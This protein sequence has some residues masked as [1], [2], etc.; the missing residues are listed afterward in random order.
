MP[1][2][3][4]FTGRPRGMPL[5]EPTMRAHPWTWTVRR[6]AAVST[7]WAVV[8]LA[9]WPARAEDGYDLWL[10]YRPLPA[11]EA[12]AYRAHTTQLV[13]DVSTPMRG[14]A[15]AELLRAF[16]G[17]LGSAPAVTATITADGAILAGTPGSSPQIAGLH[18]SLRALG[19]E[20]YMIRSVTV[21]GHAATVIAANSD[22]GVL[23]G[24]FR[25]LRL[26][27][28]GESLR[29]LDLSDA[30]REKLR[31]L[32]H[33]DNLDGSVERGYAGNS[34]WNWSKLPDHLDP[35]YTDYA[36]AN[37]SIGINGV[38][39]N[40]VNA[41]A[42]IL[43]RDY[44]LKVAGIA[45]ALRPYGMRVYLSAR[46][47]APIELGGLKTAD[48][49][50]AAVRAWWRNK[51]DEIYA[52]VPDFGG[53]LVKANSEGQPGPGDY[54]RSHAAGAN[55]LADAVGRHRGVVMWR[56]FVY[57]SENPADRAT[58]AWTEFKPLD[59]KFRDNVLLQVKNGPIDFQPRE[60][61]SP[62]FG[63]MPGTP[64][65]MEFQVTKEYL[66]FATHLVYLGALYEEVLKAHT[67][68]GGSGPAVGDALAGTAGV[69]NIGADRDWCGSTFNQAN[70]Y[71]LGRLAWD[72]AQSARA[73]A[74]DWA[75][76]TLSHED[77]VV[78]AVVDMMMRSREAVV[79]YM[80]PLGLH[81]LMGRSHH[82]GPMPWDDAGPR[83][84]WTPVYYHRADQKGIGFDRTSTG[85]NAVAQYAPQ[86]AA[87]IGNLK[88]VPDEY[89]LWF[90]HVPWDYRMRSGQTLWEELVRRYTRGVAEVIAMR[91][92]W[93]GL[94]GR[95]D[96]ARHA[97]TAA[98]LGI[99]QE[100][101][102]WWRDASI[103]YWQS[104]NGLPM[105]P[106][107][108]APARTLE[109]YKSLW[110]PDQRPLSLS[111]DGTPL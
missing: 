66:G 95:I 87:Q 94:A 23:Y 47:S 89:L 35:R 16:S 60:P 75:R 31:V 34:I 107:F 83:P 43:T 91:A 90:H 111:G 92:T 13:L 52:L 28:T 85:S 6:V 79:D 42:R 7:L 18:L 49:L 73:I 36:R 15:R 100:E 59:G 71:A 44:L 33:W 25:L 62:L 53:F 97:R 110:A 101:A 108:A 5:V 96:A 32:D 51:A 104:L 27:Q 58:Q 19:N 30:P 106:G 81:H 8:L 77:A 41:N 21:D 55:M 12:A 86:V 50:D 105:P 2:V 67:K 46:F 4:F 99:Q 102:Q 48:P 72:P 84:E 56:A 11:E 24:A 20:G 9:A 76:M 109:H 38:V 57:S 37:A 17:L 10:R 88:T 3:N 103:A 40:N 82:Y 54:H 29:Q 26:M 70:W 98:L 74:G 14:A 64:L 63:A 39:L 65:M 1:D 68:S 69:A 78:Q 45:G 93:D 22:R 80:T 61:F